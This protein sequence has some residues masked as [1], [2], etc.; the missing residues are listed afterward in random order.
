[1]K[2]HVLLY[3]SIYIPEMANL[4]RQKSCELFHNRLRVG[5]FTGLAQMSIKAVL[6]VKKIL[7]LKIQL[8]LNLIRYYNNH[9]VVKLK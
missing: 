7:K 8:T 6:G 4:W 2:I 3:D 9:L 1:M 5:A